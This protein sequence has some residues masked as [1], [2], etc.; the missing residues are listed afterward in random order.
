MA[1]QAGKDVYGEKPLSYNVKEGQMML[2]EL[3][4]NNRIFQLGTQIH[5]TDN[6]HR[7]AE[8]IQAGTIGKIH[9]VRLWKDGVPPVLKSSGIQRPPSHFNY[10]FWLGPAPQTP[11]IPERT[12]L[13]YRY[14]LDYSG[15]VYADFW[16]HIADIAWWAVGPKGLR[17]I[18]ARG[19][20]AEGMADTPGEINIDYEFDNLRM[21]WTTKPPDVPGAAERNIG[22]YFEGDKGTLICDYETRE[23]TI[24]GEKVTDVP[25]VAQT[26]PRSPGHQQNFVDAVKSRT[27]PES[28]LEY[29]RDMTL[30]MH[31]G[32]ISWRLGRKLQW[33]AAR[34]KFIGDSEAN[35]LLTRKARKKWRLV[36]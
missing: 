34:E 23:L 1:F 4:K 36:Q 15:G 35:K 17:T 22:A 27:Q 25:G 33:D 13:T 9:T 12:H 3:H 29:A 7:V 21:H 5:A 6:Y 28:N 26:I 11:Y 20:I 10:D 2:R 32:L 30:P 31:L 19:T 24:N 8:I 18:E 14:F 16:C